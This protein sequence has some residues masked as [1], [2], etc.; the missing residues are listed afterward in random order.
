MNYKHEVTHNGGADSPTPDDRAECCAEDGRA[1]ARRS[2]TTRMTAP[3][4]EDVPT[5]DRRINAIRRKVRICEHSLR[6]QKFSN[7]ATTFEELQ[8]PTPYRRKDDAEKNDR[9]RRRATSRSTVD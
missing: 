1:P 3:M 7:M 4:K 9:S 6:R 2:S 5:P 8:M